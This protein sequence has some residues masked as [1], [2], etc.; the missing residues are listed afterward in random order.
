MFFYLL[1][2]F[3]PHFVKY[4]VFELAAFLALTNAQMPDYYSELDKKKGIELAI[5]QAADA[6]NRPQT[7]LQSA[8]V[9]SR[10][11]VSTFASG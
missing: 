8:P 7:P 5:A 2:H 1:F 6:Q 4:F 11:F 9:L 10:R 3:F